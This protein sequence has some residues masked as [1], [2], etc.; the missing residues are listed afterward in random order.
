MRNNLPLFKATVL[1][2]GLCATSVSLPWLMHPVKAD[3]SHT[4][5]DMSVHPG[6]TVV[7][8]AATIFCVHMFLSG[9]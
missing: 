5:N 4:A 1:S 2:L 3:F 6:C 7:Y 9:P 8:T